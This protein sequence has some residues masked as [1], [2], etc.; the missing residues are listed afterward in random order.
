M[1]GLKATPKPADYAGG[2]SGENVKK[3]ETNTA[4]PFGV[5]KLRT[6]GEKPADYEG[7][8]T[9]IAPKQQSE[10]KPAFAQV[11]L[12]GTGPK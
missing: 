6:T 1:S 10:D 2:T 5:V 12:K 4:N 7:K 3:V 11:Q 9:N 8:A